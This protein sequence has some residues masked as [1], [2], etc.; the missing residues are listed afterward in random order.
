MRKR[1]LVHGLLPFLFGALI[2]CDAGTASGPDAGPPDAPFA[3]PGEVPASEQ[4]VGD[5]EAGYRALVNFGYVGCGLPLSLYSTF[6]G[7]AA[8]GDRIP[9]REGPNEDLPYLVNAFTTAA[10]VE[11]V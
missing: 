6:F 5:P 4:R 3:P 11:V 9:G 8:G 1:P 2:G 10:G 7:S